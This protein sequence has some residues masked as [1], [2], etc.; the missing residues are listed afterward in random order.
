MDNA[1]PN[2]LSQPAAEAHRFSRCPYCQAVFR[3][4]AEKLA[5]RNGEVRCG[6]C[7][8]VFNASRHFVVRDELGR[9]VAES[10]SF[11]ETP[12]TA[13]SADGHGSLDV[14]DA[15][16]G[17]VEGNPAAT[18][19]TP[20]DDDSVSPPRPEEGGSPA[21]ASPAEHRPLDEADPGDLSRRVTVSGDRAGH[22]VGGADDDSGD[23]SPTRSPGGPETEAEAEAGAGARNTAEPDAGEPRSQ[24]PANRTPPAAGNWFN[25]EA[26][27][28]LERNPFEGGGGRNG[29]PDADLKPASIN[30]HGVD[31]YIEDRPNPLAGLFWFIV[32]V[33]FV[34]LLGFQVRT[35]LVERYA[36]DEQYRPYLSF[37]CRIAACELPARRDTYR[38]AITN[39]RIDLHPEEPGALRITVKL[40][41]QASFAQPYPDLLL[42]LTDRVGRVVGRRTFSPDFY[43]RRNASGVL[44][45]GELGSVE[46]DLAR[47]HEK[48]VGFVVDIVRD[49][50][51]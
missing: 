11:S 16:T 31:A 26:D 50:G 22:D 10:R 51:A 27:S 28:E 12:V 21:A 41:N 3:V 33:G 47:P 38:F 23:A 46:F 34:F 45:S 6:A 30:M 9:F 37:F 29:E 35:Y 42:T 44:D 17:A 39:T 7:R 14:T 40:V 18:I 1:R 15:G 8:E 25:V 13:N 36:Q 49:P 19:P 2:T 20:G 5:V 4:R 24:E 32:A 43:L 48:A